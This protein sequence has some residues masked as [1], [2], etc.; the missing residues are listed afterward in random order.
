MN[1]FEVVRFSLR[2]LS[3]NKLRSS[4]TMLGILIG[5]AAVIL[6]VAVGNGSA[7]AIS[8]RIEALGTDTITV[9][10]TGRGGSS[11]TA[12][13]RPMADALV[14]SELAPDIKS[15]SPVVSASSATMTYEGTDHSVSTFVGTVPTWFGASSTPVEKGAAFTAD[16]VAQGRR[17]VV[18]GQTV[19]EELFP[20]VDP[21]DRQV[22]V[23]GALFTVIGVLKE[24]SSTGF[25]DANDTAVAPLT[26]VQQVLSGY[27]A[28]T[29]IIVEANDPG[30]VNLVQ[31]EVA[32]ILDQKLGVKSSTTARTSGGRTNG[33]GSGT[34]YRIQNA[35][36]LLETQTA[37]ADTF[38]TLLGAVAA[39]SLLVGGIGITNIML[40]TV[41]ERTREIGIRKALGAPRR[42]ILTQFL[43]EATLLSVLGGALGVAAALI[44]SHFTIV[45]VKPVIV[46]SS[47]G[48]AVGVSIAIG[49]FF[50]GLPAA[51][52]ARLRPIDALRY[53]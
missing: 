52:A 1:F 6:L 30:R 50:G 41:T 25:Q 39:I 37:T 20:G 15:V 21:I 49:L 34:P 13:T 8:D 31:S 3:A 42:V 32:T 33:T 14:N 4:L 19:A 29:S 17:V 24:K 35:S 11:S 43:I 7:K 16:D 5:V 44:G 18:I 23:S 47:I 27:G 22:T 10:S 48:L 51:R 38:T 2:G 53:E 46:P 40:V 9:M 28:L 26:A 45:G 36:S 12:L